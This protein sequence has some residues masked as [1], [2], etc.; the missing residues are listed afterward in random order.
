MI[1]IRNYEPGLIDLV[2][3]FITPFTPKTNEELIKMFSNKRINN[4]N[5]MWNVNHITQEN[6]IG[7]ADT[8]EIIW[9]HNSMYM[10]KL[11]RQ[12]KIK[13]FYKNN[14]IKT[15]IDHVRRI[16]HIIEPKFSEYNYLD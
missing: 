5:I 2:I 10:N 6:K 12:L 11:K 7:Y 15:Y 1:N 13:L 14:P 3:H 16:I 4:D 8:Y 9:N